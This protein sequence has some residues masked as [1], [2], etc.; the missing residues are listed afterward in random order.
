MTF[1][2]SEEGKILIKEQ[3]VGNICISLDSGKVEY[4][5]DLAY[6]QG[7]KDERQRLKQEIEKIIKHETKYPIP[8]EYT[9][10]QKIKEHKLIIEN[11]KKELA[12]LFGDE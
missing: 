6:E 12:K 8:P 5:I 1:S 3:R 7:R 4:I 9:N 2:E 10:I 11:I